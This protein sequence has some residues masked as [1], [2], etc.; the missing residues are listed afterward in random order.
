MLHK[1]YVGSIPGNITEQQLKTH[2]SSVCEMV[3][4]IL[5]KNKHN[6][7]TNSGFGFLTVASAA[8][9]QRL[10]D[11]EHV[12]GGR[13]IK[14]EPF[15][16][17][18]KLKEIRSSLI[19]KRLYISDI[20]EQVTD[21]HIEE[22]F[23][24]FG[25][26]ESAYKVKIQ[27]TKKPCTFGYVTFTTE[28]PA[29]ALI[30][31]GFVMIHGYK[32][33]VFPYSKRKENSG[34]IEGL[35]EGSISTDQQFLGAQCAKVIKAERED[36]CGRSSQFSNQTCQASCYD[37]K[38]LQL[39]SKSQKQK[40]KKKLARQIHE[41]YDNTWR[42]EEFSSVHHAR[43]SDTRIP[44]R[45]RIT[46]QDCGKIWEESATQEINSDSREHRSVENDSWDNFPADANFDGNGQAKYSSTSILRAE[47]DGVL[48]SACFVLVRSF[49]YPNKFIVVHG[50]ANISSVRPSGQAN[51]E[52]TIAYGGE[53]SFQ[54]KPTTKLYYSG[55]R[56]GS[57]D[58][59]VENLGMKLPGTGRTP[60][61]ERILQHS[62]PLFSL[63]GGCRA[64][65]STAQR[66]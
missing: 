36:F 59:S 7:K 31:S 22:F 56:L 3:S 64:S 58:H 5:V 44:L 26:L 39:S 42:Q 33:L 12:V 30:K 57:L 9:V 15:A 29:S 35:E 11:M 53:E 55:R 8:D 51:K 4:L 65:K 40:E 28:E 1:L 66:K 47:S 17:G 61:K 62:P 19:R 37:C 6:G 46:T 13:K 41:S 50:K 38:N 60:L 32:I 49:M 63:F 10:Q 25:T 48:P 52:P 34:N 45:T 21:A 18:N 20:P 24:K 14:V 43:V 23:S 27:S 16:E 54:A 2:F